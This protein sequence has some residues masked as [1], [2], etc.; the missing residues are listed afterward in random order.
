[1]PTATLTSISYDTLGRKTGMSDPDMGSWSYAIT[2]T[3]P[4]PADRRQEPDDQLRLRQPG[5]ADQQEHARQSPVHL[6]L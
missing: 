3:A 1:M 4:W 6:R 2:S 5:S